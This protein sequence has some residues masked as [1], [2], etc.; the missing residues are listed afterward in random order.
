[1]AT[2]VSHSFEG[3]FAAFIVP[4]YELVAPQEIGFYFILG[5]L[6]GF[7]SLLKTHSLKEEQE[8]F[9]MVKSLLLILK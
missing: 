5:A 7:A 4:Q 2:V 9:P 6:A 1:M 3:K 8:L